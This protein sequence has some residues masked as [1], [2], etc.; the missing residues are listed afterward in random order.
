MNAR[1]DAVDSQLA[2]VA[3]GVGEFAVIR[4]VRRIRA[5]AAQFDAFVED[6]KQTE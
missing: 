3:C 6:A 1:P 2:Y 4:F 5:P